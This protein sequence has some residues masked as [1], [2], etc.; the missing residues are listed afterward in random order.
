MSKASK[1]FDS[2]ALRSR[3]D[4]LAQCGTPKIPKYSFRG[5]EQRI[6]SKQDTAGVGAVK[7]KQIYTGSNMIG[8]ATLHKSNAVPVFSKED[9]E[10][11]SKMR[12]G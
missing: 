8:I 1:L 12:R 3:A 9:A 2:A 4:R 5:Q 11:I 10:D 6:P 7:D